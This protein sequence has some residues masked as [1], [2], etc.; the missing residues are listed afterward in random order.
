MPFRNYLKGF[1]LKIFIR[2]IL[3]YRFILKY[4]DLFFFKWYCITLELVKHGGI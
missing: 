1:S 4:I 2:L 3:F